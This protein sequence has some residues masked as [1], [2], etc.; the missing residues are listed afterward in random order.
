[1]SRLRQIDIDA[2]SKVKNLNMTDLIAYVNSDPDKFRSYSSLYGYLN[3]AE[4]D[5]IKIFAKIYD[6]LK[7]DFKGKSVIDI[8]PG[9]GES[10]IEARN[11]GAAKLSFL[12]RDAMITRYC[13]LLGFNAIFTDYSYGLANKTIVETTGK[14]DIV[15]CKGAVNADYIN[16]HINSGDI[17]AQWLYEITGEVCIFIPTWEKG[18][19][20]NGN[21]YTCVGER[22]V[23]YLQSPLHK[24]LIEYGFVVHKGESITDNADRFPITYILKK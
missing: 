13:E 16:Q 1:M 23:K 15:F 12:D 7:I 18:E 24:S 9:S 17:V 10:L 22:M 19:E 4:A 2:W 6:A 11:R 3:W 21:Y 5:K 20:V 14:H 8:G